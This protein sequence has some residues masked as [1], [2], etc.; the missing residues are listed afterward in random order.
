MWCHSI[1]W[2]NLL[3]WPFVFDERENY[4]SNLGYYF[5]FFICHLHFS[6]PFSIFSN[7]LYLI[8]LHLKISFE[9]GQNRNL[10]WILWKVTAFFVSTAVYFWKTLF[11]KFF[12]IEEFFGISRFPESQSFW[13]K[14]CF[15]V[16]STQ[17][18][19]CFCTGCADCIL[20]I[21][22]MDQHSTKCHRLHVITAWP[23]WAK[24]NDMLLKTVL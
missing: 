22:K 14:A 5:F 17:I 1:H 7:F 2:K 3:L 6:S 8:I 19:H 15:W 16:V 23:P 12:K 11:R 10:I 4:E 13:Q 21:W 18:L 24:Q 9:R 20:L